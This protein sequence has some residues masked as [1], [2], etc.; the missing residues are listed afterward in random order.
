MPALYDD[1]WLLDNL[2]TE[3]QLNHPLTQSLVSPTD[4]QCGGCG[5]SLVE[6]GVDETGRQVRLFACG[7]RYLIGLR[8]VLI[9]R[10]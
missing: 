1:S 7:H 6:S 5:A 8:T 4:T 3:M 2:A 9:E 10:A